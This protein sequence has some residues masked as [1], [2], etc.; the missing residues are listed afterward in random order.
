MWEPRI[1][2]TPWAFTPYYRDSFTFLSVTTGMCLLNHCPAVPPLRLCGRWWSPL[3]RGTPQSTSQSRLNSFVNTRIP[4]IKPIVGGCPMA[5]RKMGSLA[6]HLSVVT[7]KI[8]S[9]V[10]RLFL[11]TTSPYRQTVGARF[12]YSQALQQILHT[13][14][15]YVRGRGVGSQTQ[16]QFRSKITVKGSPVK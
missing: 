12:A 3:V 6:S 13:T 5:R 1:L 8:F 14:G 2:T 11:Y 4:E 16:Y 10:R 9:G 7:G 15:T